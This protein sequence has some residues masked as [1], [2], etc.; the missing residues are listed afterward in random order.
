MERPGRPAPATDGEP[1]G[2]LFEPIPRVLHQ[3]WNTRE[4]PQRW[5][6]FR[7]S[8]A[9]HHPGWELRLWTGDDHRRLIRERYSWFAPVYEGFERDIQRVDAAKY[10][11]LFECGGIYADL[12][13]ECLGSVEPL[14]AGG[15]AVVGRTADGVIEGA[16]FASPPGH[17]L[18]RV[19]FAEM[20]SPPL[21]ARAVRRVPGFNASH[22]LLS[23][24]PRMLKRAVRTYRDRCRAGRESAG[25]TILDRR[26]ISGRS[27][28]NRDR[29]FAE[30]EALVHH[31]YGHSWLRPAER[32]IV[33]L[34]T[35]RRIAAGL[36]LLALLAVLAV[37]AQLLF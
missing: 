29:P 25:I 26:F 1:L 2:T 34:L 17:P 12:D 6:G 7:D 8:W 32:R 5:A 36:S 19:A 20:G 14:L 23:T 21:A 27:W 24:G 28:L 35:R 15:G 18:W 33:A 9:A 37:L 16:F 13:C 10:F 22:V 11:I 31:H 4:V 30:P 3:I